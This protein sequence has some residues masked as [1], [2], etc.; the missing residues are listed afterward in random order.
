MYLSTACRVLLGAV[1]VA[2]ALGKLSSRTRMRDFTESLRQLRLMP[3]RTVA[4]VAVALGLTEAAVPVLLIADGTAAAGF[5]VALGL[6]GVLTA[7]V[8]VALVRGTPAPCRCF[9][10]RESPLSHWHLLRNGLLAGAAVIGLTGP[11]GNGTDPAGVLIAAVAGITAAV[12]IICLDDLIELFTAVP[13]PRHSPTT[14]TSDDVR[15]RRPG[16]P[17]R[18]HRPEPAAD[19]RRDQAPAHAHGHARGRRW[20]RRIAGLDSRR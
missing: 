5:T 14:R 4:S 10:H 8:A 19:A 18:G 15:N 6:L 2:A 20:Q 3:A 17:Q 9:G 13:P 7:G 11:A 1:F 16:A 12:L